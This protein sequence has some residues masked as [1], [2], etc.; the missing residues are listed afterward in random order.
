MS[1]TRDLFD[2]MDDRCDGLSSE[3]NRAT[4]SDLLD[5]E[6]VLHHD[7]GKAVLV[8]DTG[9]EMRAVWIPKQFIEIHKDGKSSQATR[10]DGQHAVLPVVTITCPQWLAKDKGLI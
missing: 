3:E 9:K 8:S 5:F 1:R 2:I 4:K 7:T 6:M 10:T